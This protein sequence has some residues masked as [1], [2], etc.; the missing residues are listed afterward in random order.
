MTI[1]MNVNSMC[2]FN[3]FCGMFKNMSVCRADFSE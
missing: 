2:K 3:M 1:M